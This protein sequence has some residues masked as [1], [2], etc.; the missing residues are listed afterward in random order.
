MSY[1]SNSVSQD[2]LW[3]RNLAR[4]GD[5]TFLG[6]VESNLVTLVSNCDEFRMNAMTLLEKHITTDHYGRCNRNVQNI[7]NSYKSQKELGGSYV[8]VFQ[9][10]MNI[11]MK[12]RMTL[13]F[14]NEQSVP[15]Y[16]TEKIYHALAS[17]TLPIYSGAPP[18]H[19]EKVLP[20]EN[21]VIFADNFSDL[22]TLAKYLKH[23][24]SDRSAYLKYF[25][26]KNQPLP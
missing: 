26:W 25:E 13:V 8:N 1:F 15:Y 4:L 18:E 20:C 10:K 3:T 23:L 21:C 22:Y 12:Y 2:E 6:N 7:P 16:V 14:E 5:S 19:V 24:M 17:G 9:N 11:L